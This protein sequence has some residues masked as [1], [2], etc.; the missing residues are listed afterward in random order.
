MASLYT[1]PPPLSGNAY[2][3]TTHFKKGL[4]L[5]TDWN[6]GLI[7]GFLSCATLGYAT[8][9]CRTLVIFQHLRCTR[10]KL[11]VLSCP[12]LEKWIW[13]IVKLWYFASNQGF[14]PITDLLPLT[15]T[16]PLGWDHYKAF[17][18]WGQCWAPLSVSCSRWFHNFQRGFKRLYP[19]YPF[20]EPCPRDS[21]GHGFVQMLAA[22]HVPVAC[23]GG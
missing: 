1:P 4:P 7:K 13:S 17:L 22:A 21:P 6:L 16:G 10:S 15:C 8:L 23:V 2:M 5:G 11:T 20:L 18:G 19:W 9:N 14:L 12:P 3:E